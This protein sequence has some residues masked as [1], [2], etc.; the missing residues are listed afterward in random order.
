MRF[1]EAVFDSSRLNDGRT[2]TCEDG[3]V[4]IKQAVLNSMVEWDF[5]EETEAREKERSRQLGLT[6]YATDKNIA[7][8]MM[9]S[10]THR[11]RNIRSIANG[12]L[13]FKLDLVEQ[14]LI[15]SDVLAKSQ[16]LERLSDHFQNELKESTKEAVYAAGIKKY[17]PE[18]KKPSS[19][20]DILG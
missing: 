11:D 7:H 16:G 12:N 3:T 1:D 19:D 9:Q 6:Q 10:R 15:E 20:F 13:A 4:C 8:N 14:E 5:K 18:Q 2:Y 17:E